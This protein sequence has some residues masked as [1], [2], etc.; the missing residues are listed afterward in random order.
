MGYYIG[1][2]DASKLNMKYSEKYHDDLFRFLRII[3]M[4]AVA[5]AAIGG[6]SPNRS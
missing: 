6:S 1:L 3:F 2:V 4:G 5:G